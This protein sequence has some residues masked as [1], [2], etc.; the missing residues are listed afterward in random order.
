MPICVNAPTSCIH[1]L[2]LPKVSFHILFE[3]KL[4]QALHLVSLCKLSHSRETW[5]PHIQNTGE[6]H[7]WAHLCGAEREERGNPKVRRTPCSLT[8]ALGE[9]SAQQHSSLCL[10]QHSGPKWNPFNLSSHFSKE[11]RYELTDLRYDK[12]KLTCKEIQHTEE[13]T[14]CFIGCIHFNKQI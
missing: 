1:I 8:H 9:L 6:C 12:K 7:S 14:Q 11:R 10:D 2:I 3:V 4:S 5:Q 13:N